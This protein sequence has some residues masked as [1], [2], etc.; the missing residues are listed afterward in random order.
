MAQYITYNDNK[1]DVK[2]LLLLKGEG[3]RIKFEADKLLNL[4]KAYQ[5]SETDGIVVVPYDDKF[6]VLLKTSGELNDKTPVYILS[7]FILKKIKYDPVGDKA[8]LDSFSQQFNQR[9]Q[10]V[11][12]NRFTNQ[13]GEQP[14]FRNNNP[15]NY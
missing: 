7:K 15:R 14:R 4:D 2:K 8:M 12:N 5:S 3:I 11:Q 1:Y 9:Q 10:P 6:Q 13:T